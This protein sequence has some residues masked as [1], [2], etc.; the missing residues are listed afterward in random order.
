[1]YSTYVVD[2]LEAHHHAD[3]MTEPRLQASS[4]ENLVKSVHLYGFETRSRT[5]RQTDTE[6]CGHADR[7]TSHPLSGVEI[8]ICGLS[9]TFCTKCRHAA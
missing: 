8:S 6:T 2:N 3:R 9:W 4:I 7:N 1:M 5:D